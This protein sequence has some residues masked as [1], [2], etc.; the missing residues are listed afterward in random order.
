MEFDK[1]DQIM[2]IF[3]KNKIEFIFIVG[4]EGRI[5]SHVEKIHPSRYSF[6]FFPTLTTSWWKSWTRRMVTSQGLIS[7]LVKHKWKRKGKGV[8][9]LVLISSLFLASSSFNGDGRKYMQREMAAKRGRGVEG[10]GTMEVT[11]GWCWWRERW[12]QRKPQGFKQEEVEVVVVVESKKILVA[13]LK[14]KPRWKG[15][16]WW[17]KIYNDNNIL[18]KSFPSFFFFLLSFLSLHCFFFCPNPHFQLYY[19]NYKYKYIFP[20]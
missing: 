12:W 18:P 19:W 7:G 3:D 14:G 17:S 11:N 20:W 15:K 5:L 10:W 13:K 4:H 8:C 2:P 9:F 16:R 6:S 1:V